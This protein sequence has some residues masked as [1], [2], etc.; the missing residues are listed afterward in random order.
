[1]SHDIRDLATAP[2]EL[3]ALGEPTHEEPAFG[4]IRNELFASLASQGFRSIALET[5]RVSALAVDDF[6]QYGAGTLDTAMRQGFSHSYGDL[7][8]VAANR[9]LVA[10]MREY[11]Q[12]RP[13][14]K[15][16]AFHG[17]DAP[18]ENT[19]APSPR[20]YLEFTCDY[21]GLDLD[22][23][24]LLGT[25]ERWSRQEAILDPVMSVG[26]SPE[27][28]RLRAIADDLLTSLYTRAPEL[29]AATARTDWF[30]ARTYLATGLG[31]LRYHKQAAQRIQDSAR[32]SGLLAIR[33]ALMAQNLLDIRGIEEHRGATL[34]FAHN[35]HLQRN[36]STMRIAGMDLDWF[37]AG[38]IVGSLLGRRYTVVV[39]SLGRSESLGLA[40]PE[41]NTYEGFLQRRI[42]TWGLTTAAAPTSACT[43]TDTRLDRHYSPLDRAIV[44]SADAILHVTADPSTATPAPGGLRVAK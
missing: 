3:L 13:A 32:I 44:D 21:L 6:V 29:I 24:S 4:H 10:W 33:A 39:G 20:R 40:E 16:L 9:R 8:D 11:N 12:G 42:A 36:V 41:P 26:D 5:D 23:A 27:A 38:A 34:V 17:F 18:T 35:A 19:S 28:A 1:M 14:E 25:D 2:C 7:G 15:R 43:R 22:L 37:S 31:L 30:R